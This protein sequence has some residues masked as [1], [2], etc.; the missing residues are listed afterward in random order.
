[1]HPTIEQLLSFRDTHEDAYVASHVAQCQECA[2]ILTS[3]RTRAALRNLPQL[4][5]PAGAWAAI[6]ARTNR[7][8]HTNL[9]TRAVAGFA[10]AAGVAALA[11][12]FVLRVANDPSIEHGD[13]KLYATTKPTE[14]E[15]DPLASL[16]ERSR[17][18]DVLLQTLPERPRVERVSTAATLDTIE[19][20]IQWLD[21]QLSYAAA[22]ELDE[23][24]A[25]RLWRERV[26][27]MDS[28]VKVRYAQ[29]GRVSF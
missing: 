2:A 10:I 9:R 17:E 13:S 16:I 8:S 29:S 5:A 19:E 6:A 21:F 22:G 14:Q 12:L 1:M 27:L 18:L 4:D 23:L 11:L 20:R 26:E 15:R 28:L 24:E 25:R 7:P 3:E